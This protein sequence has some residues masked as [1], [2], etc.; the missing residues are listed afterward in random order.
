[1]NSATAVRELIRAL[2]HGEIGCFRVVFGFLDG[3][4][5]KRSWNFAEP[6]AEGDAIRNAETARRK[7]KKKRECAGANSHLM[8]DICS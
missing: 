7:Q 4:G 3:K 6:A 2:P 5:A 8:T 1:M